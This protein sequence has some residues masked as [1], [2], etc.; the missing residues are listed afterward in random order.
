MQ[1]VGHLKNPTRQGA[2]PELEY[3]T[4]EKLTWN[5]FVTFFGG[6]L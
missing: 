1:R 2:A 5:R 6:G 3:A 4:S